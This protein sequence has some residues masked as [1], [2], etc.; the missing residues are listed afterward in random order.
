MPEVQLVGIASEY[1]T[2]QLH[3]TEALAPYPNGRSQPP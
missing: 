3:S 1:D 2:D